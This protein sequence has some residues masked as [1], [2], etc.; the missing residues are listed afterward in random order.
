VYRLCTDYV[1]IMY[2][3]CIDYVQAVYRLCIDYVQVLTVY[4]LC[5]DYVEVYQSISSSFYVCL[6]DSTRPGRLN[7]SLG[8]SF[9][10]TSNH[11]A[12]NTPASVSLAN[13]VTSFVPLA[14]LQPIRTHM[15]GPPSNLLDM[16][17]PLND[18]LLTP[19]INQGKPLAPLSFIALFNNRSCPLSF[20]PKIILYLTI[21]RNCCESLRILLLV[22]H[23]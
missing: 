16:F 11:S 14:P 6:T 21:L 12:N 23:T 15:V 4:R 22:H 7:H 20:L 10:T 17:D 2:R 13:E 5:T 8:S 3:L 9:V 1:Q 19:P 18:E